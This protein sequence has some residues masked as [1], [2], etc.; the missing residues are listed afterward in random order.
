MSALS[1][2]AEVALTGIM[3]LLRQLPLAQ[4]KAVLNAALERQ[5]YDESAQRRLDARKRGA[6]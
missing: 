5:R 1:K 3:L 6:K 2:A 4:R